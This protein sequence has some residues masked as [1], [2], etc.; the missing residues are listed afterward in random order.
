MKLSR[1]K[2]EYTD[3]LF[4]SGVDDGK[5]FVENRFLPLAIDE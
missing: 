5:A 4:S 2:E 1:E 3:N